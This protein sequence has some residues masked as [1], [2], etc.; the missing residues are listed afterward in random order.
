M[1]QAICSVH[2]GVLLGGGNI[3]S[4]QY[5]SLH[6]AVMSARVWCY[7]MFAHIYGA[8]RLVGLGDRGVVILCGAPMLGKRVVRFAGSS[9]PVVIQFAECCSALQCGNGL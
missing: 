4:L 1:R 3:T 6:F 2:F 5:A 7:L 9:T 8:T